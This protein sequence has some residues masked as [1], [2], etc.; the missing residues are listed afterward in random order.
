MTNAL[1]RKISPKV[2]FPLADLGVMSADRPY[3]QQVIGRENHNTLL[4][5]T[6][7]VVWLL[8]VSLSIDY[9]PIG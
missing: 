1:V 2:H 7:C 5:S 9:L 8:W 4:G 6:L 3:N